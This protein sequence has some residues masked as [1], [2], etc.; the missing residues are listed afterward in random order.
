VGKCVSSIKKCIFISSEKCFCTVFF[1]FFEFIYDCTCAL[2]D[3]SRNE[4]IAYEHYCLCPG[5]KRAEKFQES[6]LL[7]MFAMNVGL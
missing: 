2:A 3:Q 1:E 5:Y 7:Y 6:S 4:G